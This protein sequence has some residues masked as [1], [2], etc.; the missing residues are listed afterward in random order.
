MCSAGVSPCQLSAPRLHQ[1]HG[2]RLAAFFLV[3]FSSSFL[4][5]FFYSG[6]LYSTSIEWILGGVLLSRGDGLFSTRPCAGERLEEIHFATFLLGL[7]VTAT[8]GAASLARLVPLPQ[9]HQKAQP[10]AVR[11]RIC[12]ARPLLAPCFTADLLFVHPKEPPAEPARSSG[13]VT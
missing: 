8:Q 7:L 4:F 3:F 9:Q 2:S 13:A 11:A 6:T 1:P 12:P 10:R 5:I